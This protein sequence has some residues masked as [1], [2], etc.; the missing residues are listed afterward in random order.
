MKQTLLLACIILAVF[1]CKTK[2][3]VP[4]VSGIKVDLQVERFEK[5][6]FG[7]DTLKLDASL[8]ALNQS[9][10]GFIQDFLFNIL[11]TSAANAPKDV[12]AFIRSYQSVYTESLGSLQI[13]NP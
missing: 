5:D 12:P 11:G 10:P 3:H 2:R 4:D 7:I 1:G 13:L 8:Q 6:F 9:H